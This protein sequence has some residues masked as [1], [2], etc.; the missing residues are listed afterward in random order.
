MKQAN[1]GGALAVFVANLKLKESLLLEKA[2]SID[3]L[4]K[5]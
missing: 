1:K 2:K 3:R 5:E 4:M